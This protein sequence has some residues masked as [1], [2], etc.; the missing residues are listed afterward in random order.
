[1]QSLVAQ[2]TWVVAAVDDYREA[3][4]DLF[5]RMLAAQWARTLPIISTA[6]PHRP[7]SPECAATL[8]RTKGWRVRNAVAAPQPPFWL[9]RCLPAQSAQRTCK[10]VGAAGGF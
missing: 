1:M 8:W 4:E 5:A 9:K 3:I 7:E 10:P 6:S 2:L